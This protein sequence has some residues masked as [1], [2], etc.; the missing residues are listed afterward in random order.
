MKKQLRRV[1]VLLLAFTM[2]FGSAVTLFAAD[3]EVTCPGADKVHTK[4]NCEYVAE[5]VVAP[6]CGKNGYTIYACTACHTHFVDDVT[7][8]LG[9]CS[10][11]KVVA[12][13]PATCAK[14]GVKAHKECVVCGAKYIGDKAYTDTEL[15]LQMIDHTWGE[16]EGEVAT[17]E[18]KSTRV[19][20]C[21]V[22]GKEDKENKA[23]IGHKYV[24]KEITVAP[25]KTMA[26]PGKAIAICENCKTEHEVEV[27]AEHECD[28]KD[29]KGKYLY[30]T[31]VKAKAATCTEE[32]IV[33]DYYVCK[34]GKILNANL[35]EM[36][37]KEIAE[38][39]IEKHPDRTTQ[40]VE[41]TCTDYG[42]K[43]TVCTKCGEKIGDVEI[44]KPIGHNYLTYPADVKIPVE[45]ETVVIHKKG[46][47][48]ENYSIASTDTE[49]TTITKYCLNDKCSECVNK[50]E[51]A[52]AH[53]TA[54]I[55]RSKG[56]IVSFTDADN[57]RFDVELDED[58]KAHILTTVV[59]A[60]GHTYVKGTTPADCGHGALTFWYCTN[61]DCSLALAG[62]T[63]VD[64]KEYKTLVNGKNV[65]LVL[66]DKAHPITVAKTKDGK[67]AVNANNHVVETVK[68]TV[69]ATCEKNGYA[70][71]TCYCGADGKD[72]HVVLPALGHDFSVKRNPTCKTE[73]WYKCSRCGAKD[74]TRTI[75]VVTTTYGTVT[76]FGEYAKA[77]TSHGGRIFSRAYN[78]TCTSNA[79]IQAICG[80]CGEVIVTFERLDT[81]THTMP[82]GFGEDGYVYKISADGKLVE[83]PASAERWVDKDGKEVA[84]GTKGAKLVLAQN[85]AYFCKV[86]GEF[87]DGGTVKAFGG[88]TVT[89]EV[90]EKGFAPTCE[91]TG[92]KDNY[93]K[94]DVCDAY[95]LK[96]GTSAVIKATGHDYVKVAGK[97]ATCTEDG[98]KEHYTCANEGCNKVFTYDAKTKKY[99][100]YTGELVIAATGHKAVLWDA[101]E[102]DCTK[103]AY[104]YNYCSAC[105]AEWVEGYAAPKGHTMADV[106]V[107][108]PTC[109]TDGVSAHK[110]CKNCDYTEGKTIIP[111]TGH[112][113]KDG[114]FTD[115]NR[116]G[117]TC[118]NNCN[119]GKDK[120]PVAFTDNKHAPETKDV[121]ATCTAAG[122]TMTVCT[123][124]NEVLKVENPV[125][126]LGHKMVLSKVLVEATEVAEGKALYVCAHADCDYTEEV[127][128]P[129]LSDL[130]L[131]ITAD[132]AVVAGETI[133]ESGKVKV[134]VSI[135]SL[136]SDIWGTNFTV[137]YDA[138]MFSFD[139]AKVITENFLVNANA[140]TKVVNKATVQTGDVKVLATAKNDEAGNP[141]NVKLAGTETLVELYF[142]VVGNAAEQQT[143]EIVEPSAGD[144]DGNKEIKASGVATVDVAQIADVDGIA[145]INVNDL[146]AL[147]RLM[148][149]EEYSAAADLDKDGE[150]TALDFTLLVNYLSG[151]ATMKDIRNATAE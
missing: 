11:F 141:Q 148:R 77:R 20:K 96:D 47:V 111:A 26:V 39:V 103:T 53:E 80:L 127:V 86:C 108:N 17:C 114:T 75:P 27:W 121:L 14:A 113:D 19:R 6:L 116:K 82:D 59:K 62:T 131:N 37:A 95:I 128:I 51:K 24:I 94:C 84:K 144:L 142:T 123:K 3:A 124:C 10:E 98:V 16:W 91:T 46:E 112:K 71:G 49:Q 90:N 119:L 54:D 143:F 101:S 57:I 126:A 105:K 122:Y 8:A 107:V 42:F 41:P 45:G 4:A 110:K 78:A 136:D 67:E 25:D 23:A 31:L 100:E 102:N 65:H 85:A 115:C 72:V 1:L 73:G 12:E 147:L 139:S 125:A 117:R 15:E 88:H 60:A 56:E 81:A 106:K 2:C 29:A 83:R 61:E 87:V 118:L 146:S 132:N 28:A 134:T 140:L 13:V 79:Y 9:G 104:K 133:V 69:P 74:E 35:V 99:V 55:E 109:T 145:G 137:K 50:D 64:G 33:A 32:G 66:G 22:C 38:N 52:R 76:T 68:N 44:I 40:T 89:T 43:T 21:T 129:K 18:G 58:V 7:P 70:E 149:N 97:K 30:L 151:F 135:S 92:L 34:C 138:T 93:Y 36:T 63:T 120:K 5:E 150:I 130:K 48:V